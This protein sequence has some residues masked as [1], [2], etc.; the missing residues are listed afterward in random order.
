MLTGVWSLGHAAW[1]FWFIAA[2]TLLD[3]R[4]VTNKR[5]TSLVAALCFPPGFQSPPTA[6]AHI[7]W[8]LRLGV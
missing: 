3:D 1:P 4:D 7:I 2:A 5:W 8:T 6:R